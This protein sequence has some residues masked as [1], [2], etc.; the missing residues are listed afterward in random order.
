[1]CYKDLKMNGQ[2]RIDIVVENKVIL[3]LKSVEA[4][5]PVH[6]AQILSYMK[7]SGIRLGLLLNF[8]VAVLRA[9]IKRLII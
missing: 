2:F 5:A 9:G 6:L 3:E 7:L 8:N 4:I 1:L